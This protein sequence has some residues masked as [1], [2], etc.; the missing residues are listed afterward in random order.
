MHRATMCSKIVA[1]VEVRELGRRSFGESIGFPGLRIG[2]IVEVF[3]TCGVS[4]VAQTSLFNARG[5]SS[6]SSGRLFSTEYSMPSGPGTVFMFF[7]SSAKWNLKSVKG[8]SIGPTC[9][10]GVVGDGFFSGLVVCACIGK[11]CKPR[12]SASFR[13]RV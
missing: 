5:S 1:S 7:F 4:P 9:T 6:P 8:S 3:H 12:S 2:V 13:G 10:L 11:N